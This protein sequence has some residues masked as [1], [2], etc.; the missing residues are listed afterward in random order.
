MTYHFNFMMS[1]KESLYLRM[2]DASE[3]LM[4]L[5][6]KDE[7]KLVNEGLQK[8]NY[9]AFWE[10]NHPIQV[11]HIGDL[12]KYAIRVLYNQHHSHV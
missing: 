1:L 9:A 7:S 5:N 8:H 10:I 6:K 2:G 11:K 4:Q 3:I 12:K